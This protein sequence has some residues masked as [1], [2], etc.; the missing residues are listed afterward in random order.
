MSKYHVSIPVELHGTQAGRNLERLATGVAG[1]GAARTSRIRHHAFR[2]SRVE[3][4]K[5]A[6]RRGGAI[7]A[8]IEH[9]GARREVAITHQI[10]LELGAAPER[11]VDL[12]KT[13]DVASLDAWGRVCAGLLAELDRFHLYD[14][15][16]GYK[17]VVLFV[18]KDGKSESFHLRGVACQR[19]ELT[20]IIAI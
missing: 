15:Y 6:A 20:S 4:A 9:D 2:D 10:E 7:V 16:G 18:G 5:V 11:G 3:M 12:T 13:R 19:L 8:L 14:C 17:G 1:A